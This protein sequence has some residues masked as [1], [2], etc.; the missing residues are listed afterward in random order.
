[1]KVMRDVLNNQMELLA[2][3]WAEEAKE[4]EEKKIHKARE[5]RAKDSATERH[6][7]TQLSNIFDSNNFCIVC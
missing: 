5:Q 1:M 2:N 7:C 3:I 4:M 6:R